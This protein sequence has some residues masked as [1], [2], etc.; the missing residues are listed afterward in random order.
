M[1]VQIANWNAQK[2]RAV[3]TNAGVWAF[4]DFSDGVIQLPG[5]CWPPTELVQK[6]YRSERVAYFT[7]ED[8]AALVSARGYYSDLQSA[9]SEDAMVWSYF[10]PIAYATAGARR[11]WYAWVAGHLGLPQSQ[12]CDVSL[13]RHIPHPDTLTRGGPEIDATIQTDDSVILIEAKWR[14]SESRWQGADGLSTQIDLRHRFADTLG[15]RIYPGKRS[16]VVYVILDD[17]QRITPRS[18]PVQTLCLKW[19]DLCNCDVHPMAGEVKRY[20]DWKRS[21][22]SRRPG[23]PAPG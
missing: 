9:H 15:S 4:P 13:W 14:G 16:L 22:I 12:N 8:Q 17:S 18:G 23:A 10:G 20:Y 11:Q 6:L 2:I 3:R 5:N 19:K 7:A 21:L 1:V